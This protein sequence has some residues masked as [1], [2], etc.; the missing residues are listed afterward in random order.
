MD[1]AVYSRNRAFRLYLSSKSGKQV[2]AKRVGWQGGLG[3][4]V[5]SSRA[6]Q[7]IPSL[8]CPR[9]Q[10]RLSDS[11]WRCHPQQSLTTLSFLVL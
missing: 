2:N 10:R 6:G 1:P 3:P 7:D 5:R 4:E 11:G 8:L 9:Q